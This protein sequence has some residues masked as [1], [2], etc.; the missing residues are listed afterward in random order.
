LRLRQ[1]PGQSWAKL[2]LTSPEWDRL[3]RSPIFLD[4]AKLAPI[5]ASPAEILE[6]LRTPPPVI[7]T[8]IVEGPSVEFWVGSQ[9]LKGIS[10]VLADMNRRHRFVPN[11]LANLLGRLLRD[12]STGIRVRPVGTD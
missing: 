11:E 1:T 3:Q 10:P 9:R 2:L 12:P 8:R 7:P 6:K 5:E 4:W